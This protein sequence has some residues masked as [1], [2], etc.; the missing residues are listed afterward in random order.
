MP[1]HDWNRVEAGIFHS[2]HNAWITHLGEA[3]N[4]GLLPPRL[5]CAGRAT[6]RAVR[7]RY[8][9]LARRPAGWRAAA[10]A[11][12]AIGG[13][14]GS[15][16]A[17]E[18][19]AAAHGNRD[20]SPAPAL[21][22]HPARQRSSA[23]RCSIEIASP[24]NKDRLESVEEFA[25]KTD[26]GAGAGGSCTPDRLVCRPTVTIPAGCTARCGTSLTTLLTTFP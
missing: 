26:R 7:D 22:R 16:S 21:A 12:G 13:A 19:A 15:R 25:A 9:D 20:V 18:S 5:L 24:A 2:F 3:L 17:A 10:V 14:G 8:P 1:I 23:D 4:G 11:P 6:R